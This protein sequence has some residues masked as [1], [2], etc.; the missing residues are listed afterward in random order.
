VAVADLTGTSRRFGPVWIWKGCMT[1]DVQI[2]W[3]C[4]W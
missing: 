3:I 1:G 2:I 4:A